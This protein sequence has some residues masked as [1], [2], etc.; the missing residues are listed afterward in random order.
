MIVCI[1][2]ED[3]ES[4]VTP[5]RKISNTS[6]TLAEVFVPKGSPSS[7]NTVEHVV[8]VMDALRGFSL[9]PLQWALDHVIQARCTI[10][11]LGVMPWIPL[12]RKHIFVWFI[13]YHF[14]HT[15]FALKHE[16]LLLL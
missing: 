2:G 6:N 15:I 8:I 14:L 12:A 16:M 3:N 9:E 4:D 11:L 13:K 7:I 5:P 1:K 10:T